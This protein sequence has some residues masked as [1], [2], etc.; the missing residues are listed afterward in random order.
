MWKKRN[1]ASMDELMQSR[2]G[3]T[4]ELHDYRQM[5]PRDLP[6][7]INL[8][9]IAESLTNSLLDNRI[10]LVCDYDTDGIMSGGIML[11]ALNFLAAE[12]ARVQGGTAS[13]ISLI[14]PDRFRDGYGFQPR[15]AEEIHPGSIIILLDNGISQHD[16]IRA[17]REN[18]S[19]VYIVD[20]HL[21]GSSLPDADR[22]MERVWGWD[23]DAEINVVWVHISNL[24]KKLAAL[25]STVTI[26][27]NRGLGYILETQ[28]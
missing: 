5:S 21:P 18:G 19:A 15:H 12:A 1:V 20:H 25:G 13:D 14:V 9:S 2:P 4:Y 7:I 26:H 17:A 3:A 16:A 11:K 24:R 27:A 28:S 22:I 8:R 10:V 6:E 23:S